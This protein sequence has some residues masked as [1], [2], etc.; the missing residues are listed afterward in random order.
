[1]SKDQRQYHTR[2]FARLA[3]VTARALH[4]YGRLGLLKPRRSSAG[5]RSYT[6]RDFERL[7]QIVALK[8]I[9][10]PL[11]KIQVTTR[12]SESLANALRAQRQILERNDTFWIGRSPQS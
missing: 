4:H 5:Y 9:G 10:V 7:A 3:G 6:D 1:M 12:S 2:Q 8:Y 11:K